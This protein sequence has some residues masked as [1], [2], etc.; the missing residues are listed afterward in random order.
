MDILKKSLCVTIIAA[1]FIL[2]FIFLASRLTVRPVTSS[3]SLKEIALPHGFAITV[4][5]DLGSGALSI[6][7][8]NPGPRMMLVKDNAL[9]VSVPNQGK[10][11]AL[12]DKNNDKKADNATVFIEG[13]NNPHG[14]DFSDGWFY[15]AEED[16][17]IRVKD[18]NNDLKADADSIQKLTDLPSGAGHF[19]RT[20][21]VK[22]GFVY[23]SAG[24]S[25]NVCIENDSM[26]AAI[27]RCNIDGSNC[28]TYA[29]GLRNA[30][31]MAFQPGTE[32]LYATDNGRDWLGDDL[33]QDEINF[34]EEGKDYGWPICYGKNIHDTDFDK[35]VYIRNPCMEPFETPS[36]VDLQAHSTPLGLV[37]YNGTA[38]PNEYQ[39]KLFVAYHGSWNRNVPT[40]YKI[41]II[42]MNDYSVK[43]FATGW[44]QNSS[45]IGRPV[46]IANAPDGSLFVSDDAAEKIYRISYN[47]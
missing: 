31:G 29:K 33:P 20:V 39:G 9:F 45:V 44:L 16:R 36:L 14:I 40:G 27:Q 35:N 25:C 12:E 24:S 38:F 47:R 19:T 15:I 34:I 37:F 1:L 17:V 42:N 32:K 21:R 4:Y 28:S 11:I 22:D 3:E 23:I 6:P 18:D 13:L 7:G 2:A 43:D 41:V 46:D 30:V 5:A 26:R 10:I 8:P